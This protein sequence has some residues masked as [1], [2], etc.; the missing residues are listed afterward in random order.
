MKKKIL[1]MG[2]P[3]AGKTT[4]AKALAPLLRAVH[5][6]A[7]EVRANI[8][9]DLGFSLVDRIE[10]ARRMGWLCDAVTSAGGYAIAD[11]ICPTSETREAFGANDAFVIWLDRVHDSRFEDTDRLFEPPT[12]FDLRVGPE[13]TPEYWA[14]RAAKA[15]AGFS[16]GRQRASVFERAVSYLRHE[17]FRAHPGRVTSTVLLTLAALSLTAAADGFVPHHDNFVALYLAAGLAGW[18]IGAVGG[19]AAAALS[20]VA[21]QYL[22]MPPINSFAVDGAHLPRFLEFVFCAIVSLAIGVALRRPRADPY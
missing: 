21:V 15:V 8:H 17:L 4:L 1:I 14:A 2:L 12:R 3:G 5:L 10:N 7:D 13:G 16:P 9:K 22:W 6:N 11:F 18:L 19:L 20:V